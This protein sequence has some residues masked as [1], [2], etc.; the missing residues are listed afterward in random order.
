MIDIKSIR[1]VFISGNKE[2]IALNDLDLKIQE[3][4]FISIVGRSGSGKSTLLHLIGILDWPTSGDI[5]LDDINIHKLS[6]KNQAVY[7]NKHIGFVF[8]SYH[9]EPT[10]TVYENIE[11][12]LLIANVR[13]AERK[14][15][16]YRELIR[17]GLADRAK[18]I[19]NNLSGGEKQRVAIAR[20]LVNNPKIV[21]ADEPC[22]N[23]DTINGK[24]VMNILR[25]LTDEGITVILVTHNMEDAAIADRIITLEDGRVINEKEIIR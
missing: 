14:D 15:R 23:L 7:R 19:V 18:E 13:S 11:M 9:L 22:G 8:Q 21:L 1:K 3:G 6:S 17:V 20:A 24:N 16:V 12:P 2:L 4:E 10:Y 5:L 25:S